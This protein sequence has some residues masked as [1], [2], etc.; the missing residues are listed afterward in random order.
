MNFE[1]IPAHDLSLAAQAATFTEA[2]AGTSVVPSRWTRPG[3]PVSFACKEPISVTAGLRA[4]KRGFVGSATSRAPVTS[5]GSPAW[6]L[7]HPPGARASRANCSG[8]L[9]E[10]RARRDRVMVLEVIE[11]NPA[12]CELYRSE[13][14][15]E[16]G[17]LC[18]WRRP[19]E[20]GEPAELP[21]GFKQV[22][23]A[24]A[25]QLPSAK[26]FPEWP[27]PISRHAIAKMVPGRAYLSGRS[28]VV[29]GDPAVAGPLRVH[30]LFSRGA[31]RGRLGVDS[32]SALC[33]S[34]VPSRARVLRAAGFSRRI[35]DECFRAS[36][37][38]PGTDQPV[39]H[40]LRSCRTAG[41]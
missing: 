14:F 17:R 2:F 24:R 21:R 23:V 3:S 39:P 29:I 27:W 11:Q 33:G 7:C 10:A 37:F 1:I 35:W 26:E 25:S 40:A 28:V 13:G 34:R 4:T 18:G 15:R 16:T 9:E 36:W 41:P 32:R 31:E 8:L 6:A 30:G 20:E 19:V 5:P 38:C 12:A 22:S